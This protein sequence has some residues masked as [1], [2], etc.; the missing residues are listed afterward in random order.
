MQDGH[1]CAKAY[2]NMR[3]KF[4]PAH[5]SQVYAAAAT[6]LVP[7]GLRFASTSWQPQQRTVGEGLVG[8]AEHEVP[9]TCQ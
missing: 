7:E 8:Q 4:D 6:A 5:K 9:L 1:A 2:T 3:S